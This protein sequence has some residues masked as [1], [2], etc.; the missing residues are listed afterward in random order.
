M[1]TQSQLKRDAWHDFVDEIE[2]VIAEMNYE[3]WPGSE[4]EYDRE[5][6]SHAQE[7]WDNLKNAKEWG[8]LTAASKR[9]LK[10]KIFAKYKAKVR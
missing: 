9:Q 6:H 10:K 4:A 2:D 1:I 7:A 8:M 5:F 3:D